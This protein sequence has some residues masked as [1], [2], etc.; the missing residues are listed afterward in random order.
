LLLAGIIFYV[1]RTS[2]SEGCVTQN[3]MT[4]SKQ[5][6]E[7]LTTFSAS[8]KRVFTYQ[9]A[10]DYWQSKV[11]AT[12]TL[13]RL[14]RKGWLQRLQRGLYMII[15]LEAGPERLWSENALVLA[16]NL[17]SPGAVAYWSALRF[18]NMTEQIPRVQFVQTT[19]R[20]RPLMIQGV[21]FQFIHVAER[22][23][24]G[25]STRRIEDIPI[26][27]TD[28][29]KTIIDAASRPEL[30]GGII[31]LAQAMKSSV[32]SIDWEKLDRYLVQW[33]GGAVAKRLGYLVETL[34]LP[35]PDRVSTINH[36]QTMIS[37]GISQLEPG[38]G[39]SG[40]I[41]TRWQLQ[42]NVPLESQEQSME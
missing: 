30:S 40:P 39:K 41:V 37:K 34:S 21:E 32:N 42:I 29:E 27:V 24:F 28:R 18:W 4:L 7:F 10:V 35:I 12:N 13:G 2:L 36:W 9:Q 19:K 22:Y 5:E 33:G 1:T 15:P 11:A 25:I 16:S 26:I 3:I 17:I 38:S 14:V 20:K 31:Q 8:G 23:F 6:T